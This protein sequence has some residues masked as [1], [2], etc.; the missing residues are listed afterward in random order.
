MFGE[1]VSI[2][3]IKKLSRKLLKF[4]K[5]VYSRLRRILSVVARARLPVYLLSGKEKGSGQNLTALIQ[6]KERT[7]SFYSRLIYSGIPS[8]ENLG[9]SII[10]KSLSKSQAM[11]KRPDVILVEVD[12]F[13]API[14]ERKKFILIPQWIRFTLDISMSKSAIMKVIKNRSLD[15]NLRKIKKQEYSYEITRDPV[16]FDLFYRDMYLPY[17]EH[18]FGTASWLFSYRHLKSLLENGQLLLV[19]KRNEYLAGSLLLE[20]KNCLFSHSMGVR[21]GNLKYVEDGVQ[22]ASYYFTIFWAKKKG[23]GLI[24]FGYC[25]PYLQDGVFIYKKRWGMTLKNHNRSMGLGIFALKIN[26]FNTSVR[27]FL[28]NNPFV[29]ID[30]DKVKGLALAEQNHPLTSQDLKF[31]MRIHYIK[32]LDSLVVSSPHG[33]TQEARELAKAQF[34]DSLSLSD[35]DEAILLAHLAKS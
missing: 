20:R 32:G 16:K 30:G 31:L 15:N 8:R 22:T 23:Y 28:S 19:K 5:F 9:K 11:Q 33:F 7:V 21:D 1:D 17:T 2:F 35:S 18:R 25:R 34:P 26:R 10:W 29:F 3:L 13:Y 24:D 4:V 6:G 14:F 27:N 12:K